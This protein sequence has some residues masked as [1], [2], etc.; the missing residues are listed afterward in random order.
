MR[1]RARPA[2][3]KVSRSEAAIALRAAQFELLSA[4]RRELRK[5]TRHGEAQDKVERNRL[6]EQLAAA[7]T[8]ER[9]NALMDRYVAIHR[10]L[11][12]ESAGHDSEE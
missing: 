4:K 5:V 7:G 6:K 10:A 12:E 2:E 11:A 8:L 3:R 9:R 1:E